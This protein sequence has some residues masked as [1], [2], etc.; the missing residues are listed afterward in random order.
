[1]TQIDCY[2]TGE[3]VAAYEKLLEENCDRAIIC[4]CV[5]ETRDVVLERALENPT[6]ADIREV[7][8]DADGPRFILYRFLYSKDAQ[9][10]ES[11][12]SSCF[13][14]IHYSPPAPVMTQRMYT[15]TKM[16]VLVVLDRLREAV[17]SDVSELTEA[18]LE[19]KVNRKT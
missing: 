16:R 12:S 11:E 7:L 6:L 3:V 18:W 17:L 9:H 19:Q 2:L 14:F 5:K 10:R 4:R 8:K 1:M 13:F 15:Q